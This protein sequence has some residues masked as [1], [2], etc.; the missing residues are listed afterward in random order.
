M[1]KQLK[2]DLSLLGITM[3][4]GASFT[5]MKEGIKDIPPY[6]F[7]AIRYIIGCLILAI[8]FYKRMKNIDR[9]T[10]KYGIIIGAA[11]TGGGIF[12]IVGLQFTT[13]S[14]SGFITG[15]CVVFV[16]IFLSIMN[17]K[18]PDKK[19]TMGIF[20]SLLG[21]GL[22]TLSGDLGINK[23]DFLTLISAVFFAGQVIF[24]DRFAPRFDTIALTVVE[25]GTISVISLILGFFLEGCKVTFTGYSVFSILFTGI[26]C[27][28]LAYFV[29][30]EMQKHTTAT[31]AALIFLG[32]PVFSAIIAAIFLKEIM[33][34]KMVFGCILILMGM[35]ISE[36]NP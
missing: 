23:G 3:I 31:H 36:F 17:R 11:L 22:L 30:M 1:N 32:E 14:K 5:L 8:I 18:L 20:L 4:W 34:I 9:E 26:L 24:I 10:L 35:I 29:Q 2:A 27:S 12:Q 19:S 33:T 21:L 7:L 6:T 15:L 25:L 16:P 28:A 13:A